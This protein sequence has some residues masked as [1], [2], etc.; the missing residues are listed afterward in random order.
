MVQVLRPVGR[1]GAPLLSL[2]FAFVLPLLV[3]A[4]QAQT[5]GAPAVEGAVLDPDN[6]AVVAA[7]VVIRNEAT[8]AIVTTVTD[9]RGHF[10][11][12]ALPPG[13]YAVEVFVPGFEAVR[14]SG[15]RVGEGGLAIHLGGEP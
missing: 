6:K 2:W 12:P 13:T 10:S 8:A 9:G 3:P 4:M 11:A 15:I 14:R 5:S 7:A 1:F